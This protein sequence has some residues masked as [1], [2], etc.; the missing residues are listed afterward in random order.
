MLG[1]HSIDKKVYYHDTDCGGVVYYANYLKYFEEG[2][3][4]LLNAKGVSLKELAALG[5]YFVVAHTELDYKS[6]A[7]YQDILTVTTHIEKVGRC[8]MYYVQQVIREKNVLVEAK[9][10][11]VCVSK[12]LRPIALP[13]EVKE[14]IK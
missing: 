11:L 9:T 8:S 7:C 5:I 2:R 6:P 14:K 13:E 3:S 12:E 10:T 1:G 4:E